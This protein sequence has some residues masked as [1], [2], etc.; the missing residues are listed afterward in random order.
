[1]TTGYGYWHLGEQSTFTENIEFSESNTF[2]IISY[3]CVLQGCW[4]M[5]VFDC[6][7]PLIH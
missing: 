1:M 5:G 3:I 7:D 6:I 4:E 2:L